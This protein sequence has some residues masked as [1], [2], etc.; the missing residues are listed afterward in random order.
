M[1]LNEEYATTSFERLVEMVREHDRL[2]GVEWRYKQLCKAIA[3]GNTSSVDG[4]IADEE[5]MFVP[6][7]LG[8]Q[9]LDVAWDR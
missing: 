5:A 6:A 9:I 4:E 8:T 3:D 2:V 7:G 1:T